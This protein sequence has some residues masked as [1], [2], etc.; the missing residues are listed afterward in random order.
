M[1]MGAAWLVGCS[2]HKVLHLAMCY[3]Q[4]HLVIG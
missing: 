2:P 1:K 3:N 4:R